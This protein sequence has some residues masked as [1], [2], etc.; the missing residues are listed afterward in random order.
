MPEPSKDQ[1][2]EAFVVKLGKL[3]AADRA[4]LKRNAGRSLSEA[5]G[6]NMLIYYL[7]PCNLS[8]DQE[9]MY[10]LVA[11]LYPLA[12]A[13]GKGSLGKA[14]RQA[15]GKS[16][17]KGL[18]R[19][20]EVLLD[21]DESQLPFRLRQTI[22]YLHSCRVK[23]NWAGL[24]SDLLHWN[25]PDRFVQRKWAQDYY[26]PKISEKPLEQPSTEPQTL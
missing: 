15:A 16:N 17:R 18:D 10:F 25:H 24:L 4:R 19:R 14:L 1:L 2:V 13:G 9:E 23:V 11:T 3:D 7:L 26:A 8:P 21:A 6:I 22:N 12:D 20:I 5:R